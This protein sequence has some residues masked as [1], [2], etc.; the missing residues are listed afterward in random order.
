MATKKLNVLLA[1]TDHLAGQFKA[2][3][4][5]YGKFF[6]THQG[7]FKGERKTY[8][9]NPDTIDDPSA[10]GTKLV[11]TTVD[12]KLKYFESNSAEYFDALFSQEAT[13]ASGKANAELK[14]GDKSFGTFSSLELLRLKSLLEG[15]NFK[16]VYESIPVRNDDELWTPAHDDSYSNRTGIYASTLVEGS[17][18]TTTK[19]SYILPDPNI[20]KTDARYT[21]QVASKDTT[22]ELGKFTHQR[23]SGEWSH[24]QRAELL[25]RRDKLL[26]AVT[27]ALKIAN[28]VETVSSSLT[29]NKLFNYLHRAE[30]P[31]SGQ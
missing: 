29:A 26:A 21:P 25:G 20:S 13:N 17:K 28:E 23:F 18:K 22:V 4:D 9:P 10:R 19:E 24:R 15:G 7:S 14:I 12:E 5:D 2:M 27:E 11:V 30:L 3:V 16:A 8:A 6:K 1:V 31:V